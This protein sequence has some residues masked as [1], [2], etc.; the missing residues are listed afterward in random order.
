MPTISDKQCERE[1]KKQKKK[2]SG[3]SGTY[4]RKAVP[5]LLLLLTYIFDSRRKKERK[6][7]EVTKFIK[8]DS[9]TTGT[10][11]VDTVIASRREGAN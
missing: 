1:R 7:K 2:E 9:V 11:Q 6:T 3:N 5:Y 4:V 8:S 10:K